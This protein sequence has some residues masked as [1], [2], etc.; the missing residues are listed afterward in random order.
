MPLFKGF[1]C[2]RCS[3]TETF[4]EL[5]SWE[6]QNE[7]PSCMLQAGQQTTLDCSEESCSIRESGN[8]IR[9]RGFRKHWLRFKVSCWTP[10][11]GGQCLKQNPWRWD[12]YLSLDCTKGSL[13]WGYQL[14]P[15][16]PK[17][18]PE[19]KNNICNL[20]P[21]VLSRD[22]TNTCDLMDEICQ[23]CSRHLRAGKGMPRDL[24]LEPAPAP[25]SFSLTFL[26]NLIPII[27]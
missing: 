1:F 19:D 8:V 23:T 3:T 2:G 5:Y 20:T 26:L 9:P 17:L 12:Q 21:E 14:Q 4:H 15:D 18:S 24:G 27:S 10:R 25:S 22:V 6:T 11:D 7:C 13:E 16:S